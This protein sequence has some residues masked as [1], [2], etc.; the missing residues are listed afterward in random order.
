MAKRTP[1]DSTPMRFLT[2]REAAQRLGV[3]MNALKTWIREERLPA[4][5]TPGG[6]HRISEPD[7][8][9]FQR[10]LS[11]SSRPAPAPRPKIL[12]VDDDDALLATLRDTLQEVIPDSM[13]QT[14]T[15]GYEALVQVGAFR[16]DVLVLD[17]RM[18]RLDGYE[19]CR[20]LKRRRD[21]G[22]I[23]ILAVTAHSE[24][25]VRDRILEAGADDFLEKP[26]A[27]ER[28]R[29]RVVAL[30]GKGSRRSMG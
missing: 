24:G 23:R 22:P 26:F 18:P 1:A 8:V 5:R 21:T 16:P 15:D 7:L 29:S 6:H 30:L 25:E 3:T 19:V 17:I 11:E 13:V 27:I 12:V 28:F 14:A 20:R 4:L 2:T 10:R 9:D